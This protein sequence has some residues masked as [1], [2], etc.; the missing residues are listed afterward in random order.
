M[1]CTQNIDAYCNE[2]EEEFSSCTDVCLTPR[3]EPKAEVFD[4]I[5]DRRVPELQNLDA[6]DEKN[7]ILL[8][9]KRLA[10]LE[11]ENM[12]LRKD[13]AAVETERQEC[14]EECA[15]LSQRHVDIT[16]ENHSLRE[17]IESLS[18]AVTATEMHKDAVEAENN[19]LCETIYKMETDQNVAFF[20]IA[21]LNK[22]L[23]ASEA[24]YHSK[25]VIQ[26]C[27]KQ[28][29]ANLR[30][31]IR[32][33]DCSLKKFEKYSPIQNMFQEY[34]EGKMSAQEL[35]DRISSLFSV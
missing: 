30:K 10:V 19:S 34:E 15:W 32:R 33:R 25:R 26:A 17:E 20:T 22:S 8:L 24:K 4:V 9:R 12:R 7:T 28:T 23:E 11:E 29:I 27:L 6:Y 18:Q 16:L 35:V 31:T 13:L 5:E 1:A 21:S 3:A 2:L 14:T